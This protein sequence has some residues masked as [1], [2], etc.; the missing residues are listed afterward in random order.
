MP[1]QMA[2]NTFCGTILS[3][4]AMKPD[5]MKIQ[6][7]IKMPLPTDVQQL[8]SFLGMINFMQPY[9]HIPHLFGKTFYWDSNTNTEQK[10][11]L[12]KPYSTSLQYFQQALPVIVQ[13]DAS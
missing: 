4:D 7:I 10:S 2:L 6:G 5:P 1:Q 3:T 9:I 8:Q 11:L 12:S 13:A